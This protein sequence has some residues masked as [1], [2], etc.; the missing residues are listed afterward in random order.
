MMAREANWY[1]AHPVQKTTPDFATYIL[2]PDGV[3]RRFQ[4][5]NNDG[6]VVK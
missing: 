5:T 2:G 6:V 1:W 3:L 4:N